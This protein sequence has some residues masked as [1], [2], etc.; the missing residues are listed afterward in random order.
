MIA[1]F[2]AFKSHLDLVVLTPIS[3][4]EEF[5]R[6]SSCFIRHS[7]KPIIPWPPFHRQQAWSR[8]SSFLLVPTSVSP[9]RPRLSIHL[10]HL[11][12]YH[13]DHVEQGGDTALSYPLHTV[14]LENLQVNFWSYRVLLLSGPPL[15]PFKSSG[16]SRIFR[17]ANMGCCT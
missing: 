8:T 4:K 15:N 6:Q 13:E 17:A 7:D 16:T 5:P 2:V 11:C 14:P 3:A 9:P 12:H 1:L 10:P